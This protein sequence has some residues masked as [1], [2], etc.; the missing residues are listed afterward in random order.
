MSG[1]KEI[2]A[3]ADLTA[4]ID[5]FNY[6]PWGYAPLVLVGL[7]YFFGLMDV[8]TIGVASPAIPYSFGLPPSTAA[9][10]SAL[11]GTISLVG[12]LIGAVLY[13]HIADVVGRRPA[14]LITLITYSVGSLWSALSPNL[15]SIYASRLLT[16]IGIGA[17]LAVAAAYLSEMA[18]AKVRGKYQS[19]GT[20]FGFIGAG[21]TPFV[22]FALMSW[23]LTL[24]W[25]LL[26]VIGFLAAFLTIVVRRALPESPRWLLAH[27]RI[28]EARR[29]VEEME[30]RLRS[31]GKELPQY[32]VE[33]VREEVTTK[34]PL[35]KL[36]TRPY[37]WRFALVLIVMIM[38]YF[39]IYPTM[40][41]LPSF[42]AAAGMPILTTLFAAGIA[43]FGFAV[44]PFVGYLVYDRME[45]KHAIAV[46]FLLGILGLVGMANSVLMHSIPLLILFYF[47]TDVANTWL[48]SGLYIYAAENFPTE[49][50]S[51]GVAWT[52]GI[53]HIGSIISVMAIAPLAYM[54]YGL[55]GFFT[56]LAILASVGGVV[57]LLGVRTTRRSLESISPE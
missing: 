18:P 24:G 11:G 27:G 44:G 16:G 19:L 48:A 47:I 25:R 55:I 33:S 29:I 54:D 35:R 6:W 28:N 45:R 10:I 12:Y 34:F 37:V 56:V 38:Y 36:F 14:L 32:S 5:R 22:G 15:A 39:W 7:A 49:A 41:E 40:L 26:F 9:E 20:F 17:D 57:V 23:N 1:G 42:L 8:L 3:V 46:A 4:R 21:I 53:G 13:A 50:R 30:N 43:G 51:T 52:D 2:D 31:A